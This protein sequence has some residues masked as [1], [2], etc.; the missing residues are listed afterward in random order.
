MLQTDKPMQQDAS[1]DATRSDMV[2][3]PGGT[4]RMGKAAAMDGPS[5]CHDRA[6]SQ[7]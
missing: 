2:L 6:V 4:F 3:I 7:T 5:I 1:G